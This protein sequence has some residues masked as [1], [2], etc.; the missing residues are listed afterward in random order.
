[1]TATPPRAAPTAQPALCPVAAIKITATMGSP[2]LN[3]RFQTPVVTTA[4]LTAT[5][6]NPKL[7]NI[8]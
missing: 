3:P 2:S 6:E 5:V 1:M 7:P 8:R 4:V